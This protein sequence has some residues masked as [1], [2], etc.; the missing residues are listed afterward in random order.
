MAGAAD[1]LST[2]GISLFC[3]AYWSGAGAGADEGEVVGAG[4]EEEDVFS[5]R[6]MV[7]SH[8]FESNLWT[9]ALAPLTVLPIWFSIVGIGVGICV[10]R[11]DEWCTNILHRVLSCAG[12]FDLEAGTVEDG[13]MVYIEWRNIRDLKFKTHNNVHHSNYR[14]PVSATHTSRSPL[15]DMRASGGLTI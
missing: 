15:N 2:K 10:A 4:V 7:H 6:Y 8:F 5:T 11:S 9:L 13:V 12:C 14:D 1:W 3:L